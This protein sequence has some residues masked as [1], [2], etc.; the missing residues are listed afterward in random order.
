VFLTLYVPCVATFAVMMKTVGRTQA[1]GLVSISVGVALAVSGVVRFA[2][3]L[4][5]TLAA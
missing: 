4:V 1:L 2:L 5:Q 3:R